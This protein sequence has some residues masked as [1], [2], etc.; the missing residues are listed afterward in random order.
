MRVQRTRLRSPLT[1][2]PLGSRGTIVAVAIAIASLS[3]RSADR[4]LLITVTAAK[5]TE[6][7]GHVGSF[8]IN[9]FERWEGT[10]ACGECWASGSLQLLSGTTVLR[11][12]S[13][14]PFSALG[15]VSLE[16]KRHCRNSVAFAVYEPGTYQVRLICPDGRR[17]TSDKFELVK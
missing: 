7:P 1:R 10:A 15:E 8:R 12:E 17:V 14:P 13:L 4:G 6:S 9:F 11:S 5:G 2:H 3:C 16:G